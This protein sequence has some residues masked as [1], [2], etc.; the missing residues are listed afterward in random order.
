MREIIEDEIRNS[1]MWYRCWECGEELPDLSKLPNKE[2]LKCYDW[3][4][5]HSN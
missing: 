3:F 5:H 2:L 1:V 4:V